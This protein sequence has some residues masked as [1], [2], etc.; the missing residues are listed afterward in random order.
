MPITYIYTCRKPISIF[1]ENVFADKLRPAY[2]HGAESPRILPGADAFY[3]FLLKKCV[4]Y[5]YCEDNSLDKTKQKTRKQK[6]PTPFLACSFHCF[7]SWPRSTVG[8]QISSFEKRRAE[9]ARN[10]VPLRGCQF[11]QYV[12]IL[13]DNLPRGFINNLFADNLFADHLYL[14]LP[15]TYIYIYR[16]PI[17]RQPTCF[18]WT[19]RRIVADPTRGR[20][21]L[22]LSTFLRRQQF[23][24]RKNNKK[25]E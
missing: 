5:I 11:P 25:L 19:W 8:E 21:F 1:T 14:H 15:K 24:Q 20:R 16:E 6:A 9:V 10:H 2:R 17:C 4:S 18:L 13:A 22:P 23:R 3:V 12:F 7:A